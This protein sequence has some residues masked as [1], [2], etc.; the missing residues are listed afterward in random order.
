MPTIVIR[1]LWLALLALSLSLLVWPVAPSPRDPLPV[2]VLS[3]IRHLDWFLVVVYAWVTVLLVL[4]FHTRAARSRFLLCI[5]FVVILVGSWG[6]RAPWGNHP[7]S[8]WFLAHVQYLHVVGEVPAGGHP[9][10][11]YFDFPGFPILGLVIQEITGL[12]PF[13][14]MLVYTFTSGLILT[15]VLYAGFRKLLR[16]D[17]APLAVMGALLSSKVLGVV[18]N[19]FHAINLATLY[20]AVF[21]LLLSRFTSAEPKAST[22]R[23]VFVILTLAA[24]IEY[25]FTPI[26]FALTLL[27]AYF[28]DRAATRRPP[29]SIAVALLPLATLFAWE[30]YTTVY[31]F[32]DTFGHLVQTLRSLIDLQWLEP[33][34]RLLAVNVGPAYPWWGNLSRLFWW[35]TVFLLGTLEMIWR[36]RTLGQATT[37]ERTELAILLGLL[38]TVGIGF[39][40]IPVIGVVHGGLSRYLWVAPLALVPR[41]VRRL[42]EPARWRSAAVFV[43]TSAAL[44]P[45]TF[46]SNADLFSTNRLYPEEVQV[47][48][49][50][51]SALPITQ[52][53]YVYALPSY[54]TTLLVY[55]PD[56]RVNAPYVY[57]TSAAAGWDLVDQQERAFLSNPTGKLAIT[58][59]KSK[60]EF[61]T[62]LGILPEDP[63]WR[64][65]DTQLQQVDL[66]YDNQLISVFAN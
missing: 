28:V 39:F 3:A 50:L 61:E 65:Y 20:I 64:I 31:N 26:L 58:S 2:E 54:P 57:G 66:I 27:S 29:V 40:S 53:P 18:S 55:T 17:I 30:T 46:L 12:E 22:T 63:L 44:F 47:S 52:P 19:Q 41:L 23:L 8:P 1:V 43:V 56:L 48:T 4:L 42:S 15:T 14:M 32:T 24:T 38:A 9:S 33:T 37:A 62:R 25:L 45:A 59:A 16:T 5:V 10:L 36:A 35:I 6:I 11:R 13:K 49:F 21:I 34:R 60:G 7:D 51:S